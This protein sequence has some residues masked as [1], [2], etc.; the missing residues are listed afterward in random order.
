MKW[1]FDVLVVGLKFQGKRFFA[2]RFPNSSFSR[3]RKR[4]EHEPDEQDDCHHLIWDFGSCCWTSVGGARILTVEQRNK[5]LT[6][7]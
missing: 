3:L 1:S 7:G 6:E 5:S 4:L 2:P